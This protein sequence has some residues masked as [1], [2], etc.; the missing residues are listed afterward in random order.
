V[1][2]QE[3]RAVTLTDEQL[4]AFAESVAAATIEQMRANL[5]KAIG[6]SVV[7]KASYLLAVGLVAAWWFLEGKGLVK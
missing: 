5:M 1:D 3:R 7:Q 4:K 6:E 2:N